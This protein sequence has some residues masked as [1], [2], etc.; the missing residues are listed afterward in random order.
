M[1]EEPWEQLAVII[2]SI[3]QP[4]ETDQS[5]GTVLSKPADWY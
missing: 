3:G 1:P 4:T 2:Q 5:G